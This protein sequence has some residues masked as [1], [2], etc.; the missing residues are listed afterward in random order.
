M[1]HQVWHGQWLDD[2]KHTHLKADKLLLIQHLSPIRRPPWCGINKLRVYLGRCAWWVF[3]HCPHWAHH[4]YGLKSYQPVDNCFCSILISP[5]LLFLPAL[6]LFLLLFC[7]QLPFSSLY[8]LV[9][10][11]RLTYFLC[12]YGMRYCHSLGHQQQMYLYTHSSEL[13]KYYNVSF[14]P[15]QDNSVQ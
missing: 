2:T 1:L 8:L 4:H 10:E 14:I 11:K 7:H 3:N 9:K 13:L 15:H 6:H 12:N 5:P